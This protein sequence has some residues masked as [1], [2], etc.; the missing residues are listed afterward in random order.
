MS[1]WKSETGAVIDGSEEQAHGFVPSRIIPDGTTAAGEILKVTLEDGYGDSQDFYQVV[2]KL[3][4][5]DFK[6]SKIKQKIKCFEFE[7][8]K[9]ERALNMLMRLFKLT[10][11]KP[12]H[13]NAPTDKDFKPMIGKI[14]GLSIQEWYFNGNEGNW[15]S[16]IHQMD[17]SFETATGIKQMHHAKVP[18]ANDFNVAYNNRPSVKNGT[19]NSNLLDDD[20]PF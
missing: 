18:S 14:L 1:F 13:S 8:K 7:A 4:D 5:G 9:K 20:I 10:G 6:G 11:S 17:D 3:V 15:I 19:D 12:T 16:A 2:Y